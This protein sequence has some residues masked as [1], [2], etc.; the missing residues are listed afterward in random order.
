MEE[1]KTNK[2]ELAKEERSFGT[3]PAFCGYHERVPERNSHTAT[4]TTDSFCRVGRPV[5]AATSLTVAFPWQSLTAVCSV[6]WDLSFPRLLPVSKEISH[7]SPLSGFRAKTDK[8]IFWLALNH[9]N[10]HRTNA[11][12]CATAIAWID[13]K[14][15]HDIFPQNWIICK[16]S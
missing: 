14:K 3:F 2:H 5:S 8:G 4:R 16:L 7:A 9:T 13:F 15:T 6:L 12:H 10:I 1:R 11:H